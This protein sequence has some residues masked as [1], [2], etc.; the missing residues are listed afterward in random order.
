MHNYMSYLRGTMAILT[1]N[2]DRVDDLYRLQ[3]CNLTSV[4]AGV[5]RLHIADLQIVAVD[6]ANSVVGRHLG[7]TSSQNCDALLPDQHVMTYSR[8]H[9]L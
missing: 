8:E 7:G 9:V 1:E 5:L 2:F 4:V 3:S 6:Q